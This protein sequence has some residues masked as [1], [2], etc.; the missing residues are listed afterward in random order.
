MNK[1]PD[2]LPIGSIVTVKDSDQKLMIINRAVVYTG[3]ASPNGDAA[4]NATS[5]LTQNTFFDYG[6][7]VYP[8]GLIGDR[9]LFNNHDSIDEVIFRGFEDEDNTTLLNVIAKDI[10]K[11]NL[12]ANIVDN[13]GDW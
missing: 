3:D 6:M 7:V 11:N 13:G 9:Y 12:R 5:E 10:E 8:I 2:Y 1:I 4:E